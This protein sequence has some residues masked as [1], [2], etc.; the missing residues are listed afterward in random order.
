MLESK[1]PKDI[2][3]SDKPPFFQ[4]LKKTLVMLALTSVFTAL[5][6]GSEQGGAPVQK[7]TSPSPL[8][9]ETTIV[10][11]VIEQEPEA[12]VDA[13]PTVPLVHLSEQHQSASLV[14]QGDLLPEMQLTDADGK[15]HSLH[16]LL[17]D[18]VTVVCFWSGQSPAALQQLQDTGPEIV[19]PFKDRGV[20]VVSINYGQSAEEIRKVT[21]ETAFSEKVLMDPK[22][23]ALAK[24]ATRY[25]PRT[26]LVDKAGKIVWFDMEY[27][28][29]TRRHL[30]QAIECTVD[31]P[32]TTAGATAN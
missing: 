27:S 10:G 23:E 22:G 24:V 17:G 1:V 13:R 6:C 25:L 26:Y 19:G 15:S 31:E 11:R 18:R 2:S 12:I 7:T 9:S 14:K 30:I 8:K 21:E 5:G 29:S 16:A 20:E 3:L 4:G 28:P 32:G